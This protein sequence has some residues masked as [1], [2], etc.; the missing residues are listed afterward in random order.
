MIFGWSLLRV[1]RRTREVSFD[2]SSLE[3][4]YIVDVYK[5]SLTLVKIT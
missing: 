1:G 3:I 4:Y 5:V 2:W